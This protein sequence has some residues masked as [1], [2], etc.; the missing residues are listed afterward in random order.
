[1]L[2]SLHQTVVQAFRRLR[3]Y[4]SSFDALTL[5]LL[6]NAKFAK[7]VSIRQGEGRESAKKVDPMRLPLLIND[8]NTVQS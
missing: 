3:T 1:M 8:D 7:E 2:E 5:C 4:A 6:E